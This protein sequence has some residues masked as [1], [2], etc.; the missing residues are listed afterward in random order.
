MAVASEE[1]AEICSQCT[2]RE[3]DGVRRTS[4][5]VYITPK[6]SKLRASLGKACGPR[7][8]D[9]GVRGLRP[10]R[11]LPAFP[12]TQRKFTEDVC[13]LDALRKTHDLPEN[14]RVACALRRPMAQP[15]ESREPR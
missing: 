10:D 3:H 8:V 6:L 12:S 4:R 9:Q 11:D 2:W 7:V 15:A 14:L 13:E 5:R 1:A